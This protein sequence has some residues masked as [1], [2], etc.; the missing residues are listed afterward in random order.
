MRA[1]LPSLWRL[2]LGASEELLVGLRDPQQDPQQ[3]RG[4]VIYIKRLWWLTIGT[5]WSW[6]DAW[7]AEGFRSIVRLLRGDGLHEK[8]P[9][10]PVPD[11][12]KKEREA[13]EK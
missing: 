13:A 9:I 12:L 7:Q 1:T 3:A 4:I 11:W 5:P 2:R 8:P 6:R 10:G